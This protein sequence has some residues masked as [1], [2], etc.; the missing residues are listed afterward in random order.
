MTSL[1]FFFSDVFKLFW[2]SMIE[3]SYFL[4]AASSL[5]KL[6][7]YLA[8]SCIMIEKLFMRCSAIA[9]SLGL[10]CMASISLTIAFSKISMDSRFERT[11]SSQLPCISYKHYFSLD[12]LL[13]QTESNLN[14]MPRAE[15]DDNHFSKVSLRSSAGLKSSFVSQA[16]LTRNLTG[17]KIWTEVYLKPS[18]WTT[19][20]SGC[21]TLI[22]ASF[23]NF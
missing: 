1:G 13:N 4:S 7:T 8:L 6:R 16:L 2:P 19:L 12:C 5:M 18:K 11:Y 20:A 23:F 15:L 14:I 10:S 9:F 22:M 17:S 3:S 21:S